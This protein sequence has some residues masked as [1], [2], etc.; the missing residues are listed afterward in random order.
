MR[1][2]RSSRRRGW[3]VESKRTMAFNCILGNVGFSVSAALLILGTGN[4]DV[5]VSGSWT[6]EKLRCN[7]AFRQRRQK[8]RLTIKGE[9]LYFK[10]K[11]K[12][13]ELVQ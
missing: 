6:Q 5:P 13:L 7:A 2:E 9:F 12:A 8:N 4:Q 3:G 10:P 1:F 11:P